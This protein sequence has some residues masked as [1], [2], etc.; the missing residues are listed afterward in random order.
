VKEILKDICVPNRD[1]NI[2]YF[3]LLKHEVE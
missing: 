2:N 1:H 3:A